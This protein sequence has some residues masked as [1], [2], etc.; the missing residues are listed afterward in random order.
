CGEETCFV[1]RCTA[2][3]CH[4]KFGTKSNLKKHV[5]RKHEN[6]QKL[7]SCDFEGCGKS[8]KKHQQLKVHLCQHTNE[9]PFK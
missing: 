1:C 4:Q 6:Q 3:G 7:Y 5:Q 9:P 2:E 8:F